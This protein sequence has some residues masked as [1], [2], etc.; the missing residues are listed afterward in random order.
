MPAVLKPADDR[1]ARRACRVDNRRGDEIAEEPSASPSAGG[2]L[3][4]TRLDSGER[5][6][7]TGGRPHRSRAS[8]LGRGER[9]TSVGVG[10]HASDYRASRILRHRRFIRGGSTGR[11]QFHA[12]LT[13]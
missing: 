1:R 13:R 9:L 12:S 7:P 11:R 2:Y 8:A 3:V 6:S 5:D 4:W 10:G